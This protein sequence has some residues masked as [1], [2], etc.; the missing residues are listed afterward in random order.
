M[1]Q[2]KRLNFGHRLLPVQLSRYH[3]GADSRLAIDVCATPMFITISNGG[4]VSSLYIERLP[5][6]QAADQRM[7]TICSGW[8]SDFVANARCR[9]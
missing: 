4:G 1:R 2:K 5:V 8:W 6:E 7:K 3:F 9:R